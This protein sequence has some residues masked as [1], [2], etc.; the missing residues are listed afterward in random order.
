MKLKT[1]IARWLMR[2]TLSDPESWFVEWA[3]G[4]KEGEI[5]VNAKTA[6]NDAAVYAC[7]QVR[8]QDIA[9]LPLI[10]YRRRDDGGREKAT[11]HPVYSLVRRP[12]PHLSSFTWREMGQSTCDLRGNHYTRVIRDSRMRPTELIPLCDDWVRPLMSTDGVPFYDVRM[13]GQGKTERLGTSDILHIK[14][15][16]DDGFVG[17]SCISRARDVISADIA[18]AMH[19]RKLYANGARPGGLLV[20]KTPIGKE[21]RDLARSEF[22]EQ[23]G[24]ESLYSIGVAGQEFDYKP[25]GMTNLDAEW[26]NG[27]KLSR[28]EIASLFRVPPH[29]VGIMDNATFSNI[30]HQSLE[31]VTDTLMPIARRWEEELNATL[32]REDEQEE[33][34]FEFL[35]DGLLRGDF[36]SRMQGHSVAIQSGIKTPN[37]ARE[38][39]NMNK[40]KGGDKAYIPM[41]MWPIDEPRPEKTAAPVAD[42]APSAKL[43]DLPVR[44]LNDA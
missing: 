6:Q 3:T 25:V 37:E 15:R 23:F 44:K 16:S 2:S 42:P 18:A 9:K 43:L 14:E 8:S 7:V 13:Y 30:E 19:G 40:I 21:G 33:Y 35:F 1:R 20:P 27:R 32:L 29:K 38:Q 31:Y 11:D 26:I 4:T 28:S 24:G 36:L 10:L 17:K 5:R 39:E 22:N 41:N 12:R 34:Y